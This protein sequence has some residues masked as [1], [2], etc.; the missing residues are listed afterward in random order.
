M[1]NIIIVLLPILSQI[2]SPI[3][4]ISMGELLLL[5]FT[6]FFLIY[7]VRKGNAT[8]YMVPRGL[9]AFYGLPLLLTLVVA[10]QP[11]FSFREASTVVARILFYFTVIC[12]ATKHLNY[13]KAIKTYYY[14][15]LGCGFYLFLQVFFHYLLHIDLPVMSSFGN[16]LFQNSRNMDTTTFYNRYGFRPASF[17]VE[18][19][20]YAFYIEPLIIML[21]FGSKNIKQ[22]GLIG[23]NKRIIIAI[24]LSISMLFSTS[25]LGVIYVVITWIIFVISNRDLINLKLIY[26]VAI[27]IVLL[28]L[29]YWIFTSGLFEYVLKRFSTGGSIGTRLYRGVEIFG[30]VDLF[31]KLFGTGLNNL[32]NYVTYNAIY[33]NYDEGNLNY[34]VTITNRFLTSG[35]IG[36]IS[37]IYFVIIQ[38]KDN[39]LPVQRIMILVMII[40]FFFT[41]GEYLE[42]LPFIIMLYYLIPL[43]DELT[44]KAIRIRV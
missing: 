20:Y 38:F 36:G 15:C 34:A 14:I 4:V 31:T 16:L 13:E 27:I 29:S 23:N 42:R 25:N 43:K 10:F 35:I 32:S 33:T 24:F 5:V 28:I 1:Y 19:S 6:V 3:S 30:K 22:I 12:V 41:S 17:F 2:K 8:Y 18:P 44:P 11:H 7:D 26:R 39:K 37:L 9:I 21:L 40:N